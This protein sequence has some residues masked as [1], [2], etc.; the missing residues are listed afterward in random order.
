[1]SKTT[2]G[3]T[4]NQLKLIALIT[5][6]IDHIGGHLLPQYRILRII[7]R[8]SMP[9][10]AFFIAE[11]CRYTRNKFKYF[12]LMAGLALVWQLVCFYYMD[13]LHMCILVT[14]SLSILLIY[15]LQ[16]MQEKG[17]AFSCLVFLTLLLGVYFVST[18]LK[19]YLPG[20][21]IDYGFK[22]ILLPVFI[23]LGKTKQQRL[24]GAAVG[25]CYLALGTTTQWYSLIA[26]IPLALYSGSRGKH[27]YKY[28]FYIYYPAHLVAIH[29]I[30][31]LRANTPYLDW[32]K[33]LI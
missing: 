16:Y 28:L 32:L 18:K 19:N 3:L 2:W 6:T 11:G 7:G 4:G 10:Y 30:G 29:G 31:W 1:M 5:M 17:N 20:F 12:G 13:S 21:S 26:L 14:F 24:L 33:E 9:I 8:I 23:A 15:A 22:G 27:S 25:M